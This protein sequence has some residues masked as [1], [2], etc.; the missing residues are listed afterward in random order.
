MILDS[1]LKED[2]E[3]ETPEV[4]ESL[5]DDTDV[6]LT[7]E[8]ES[9]LASELQNPDELFQAFLL[10]EIARMSDSEK[11]EFINSE[12]CNLLIQEGMLAKRNIMKLTKESDLDRRIKVAALQIAKEKGDRLYDDALKFRALSKQKVATVVKKYRAQAER[13]AKI[14]QKAYIKKNPIT[15]KIVATPEK[16][17]K[18]ELFEKED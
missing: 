13:A 18:K 4:D 16:I 5:V 1:I 14:G 6:E 2:F 15:M 10:D 17:N 9:A 12:A 8:E 7:P 11:A 3:V